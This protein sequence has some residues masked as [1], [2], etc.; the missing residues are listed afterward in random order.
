MDTND[1]RI[2]N[3]ANRGKG[4]I[5]RRH[6]AAGSFIARFDGEIFYWDWPSLPLPDDIFYHAIPFA[7]NYVRDTKGPARY[8]NHSCEPNCGI[9]DLFDIVTIREIEIGE[10]LVWDYDTAQDDGVWT[11]D[12]DCGAAQCRKQIRGYR[13]L[14]PEVKA[15]YR[16]ITSGWLLAK[17][18]RVNVAPVP[19]S[20]H[21][22]K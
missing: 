2:V 9:R 22:F 20:F 15:R 13:F 3:T 18:A 7:D 5:A 4:A 6:L 14:K 17:M 8:L 16:A 1:L 19:V 10:E 11:M 21:S 12:C